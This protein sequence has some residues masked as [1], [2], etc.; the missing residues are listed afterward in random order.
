MLPVLRLSAE[1]IWDMRDLITRI[2]DDLNLTA[3]ERDQEIPSGGTKL[4]ANRVHWAKHI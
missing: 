1:K 3:A 2:M 4:I